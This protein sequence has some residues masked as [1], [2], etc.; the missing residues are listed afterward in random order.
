MARRTFKIGNH[1]IGDDALPYVIA[2]A[3]VHHRNSMPL[4]KEFIKQAAIAGAHA[5]KFQTY[6]AKRI[7]AKWAPTYWDSGSAE[8]Q[9]DIF[10]RRSLLTPENY[11]ELFRYS[12][13]MGITLLST[14]FDPDAAVMLHG[15]GMQA[16]KIASAD[17]TNHPLLSVVADFGKPVL[18]STGAA[19][20]DEIKRAHELVRGF[21]V[22][23]ALLH[24]T[25]T[26]PT[27]LADANLASIAVLRETFPETII[28]YS[29]HTQ[30]QDSELACPLSVALGARVIEKHYTLNK[31][32]PE[33]DHYHAVDQQGLIRLVRDCK[34]AFGMTSSYREMAESEKAARQ[35][36]R[37]SIVAAAAL[38]KGTKL[39]EAHLDC[40]R[41]GTG[42]PPESLPRLVGRTLKRDLA[43]DELISLDDVD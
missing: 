7:A 14:P 1:E 30:P 22:A 3:G 20:L 38:Q 40:K 19:T 33:D 39:E 41:P 23:V 2:E 17:I 27:P 26:Y 12:A 10:A 28:G 35:Y 11:A 5:I 29:D 8:T 25:L 37:R 9:Y 21:G 13:E 34:A 6:S 42:L 43:E 4:A 15:L 16:F 18:L 32:L 36:A 31:A 24:C